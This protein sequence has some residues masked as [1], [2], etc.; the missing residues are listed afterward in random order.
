MDGLQQSNP[1]RRWM[2]AH[3]ALTVGIP[4]GRILPLL[5]GMYTRLSGRGW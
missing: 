2:T 1:N 3:Y 4:S 5:F